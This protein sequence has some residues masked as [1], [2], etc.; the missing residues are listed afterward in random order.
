VLNF[1]CSQH[2]HCQCLNSGMDSRIMWRQKLNILKTN[3]FKVG[4]ASPSCATSTLDSKRV[5][6][7]SNKS[8]WHVVWVWYSFWSCMTV[9][10]V[11]GLNLSLYTQLL[12]YYMPHMHLF[13]YSSMTS[14]KG[15][16]SDVLY[17][18]VLDIFLRN[19]I[20]WKS[21]AKYKFSLLSVLYN[22]H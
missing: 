1:K 4:A 18:Y 22:P 6:K 14:L 19:L 9:D 8:E 5:K 10:E 17:I 15:L 11:T 3:M 12:H 20:I 16:Q 7:H 21:S 2:L 13:Q